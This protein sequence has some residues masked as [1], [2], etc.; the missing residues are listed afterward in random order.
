MT[1]TSLSHVSVKTKYVGYNALILSKKKLLK[2]KTKNTGSCLFRAEAGKKICF[3]S[4]KIKERAT[5]DLLRERETRTE[6]ERKKKSILSS[7]ESLR[8]LFLVKQYEGCSLSDV[9]RSVRRDVAV[10]VI[11]NIPIPSCNV[12]SLWKYM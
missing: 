5:Q 7:D 11:C 3:C 4:Q 10:R 6:R 8:R 1:V 2:K 12:E 9:R